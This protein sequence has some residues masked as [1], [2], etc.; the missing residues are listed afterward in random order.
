MCFNNLSHPP[1]LLK[2]K[3]TTT[4]ADIHKVK[5]TL[6]S[7]PSQIPSIAGIKSGKTIAHPLAHGFHEGVIFLFKTLD[8]LQ[9]GY[10]P[11]QAHLDYQSLTAQYID[12]KL[13]FD[14]EVDD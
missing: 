6:L 11:H 4:P 7:L 10:V 12:D 8:D 9:N 13:I 5:T 3:P 2:F 1:V 14:I